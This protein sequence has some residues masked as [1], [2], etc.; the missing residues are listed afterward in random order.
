MKPNAFSLSVVVSFLLFST[1]CAT[2]KANRHATP[3]GA[4]AVITHVEGSARINPGGGNWQIAKTGIALHR[5]A[6]ARTGADGKLKIDLGRYGG[7]LTLMPNSLL[8]FEQVGPLKPDAAVL[9][10]LDLR[11]GRVV[12]DTV[13]MRVGKKILIRTPDG[14]HEIH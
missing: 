6:Q 11:E 9:S 7:V 5:G 14:T 4:E 3:G 12:G 8:N 1:G 10:I 13:S 2:N